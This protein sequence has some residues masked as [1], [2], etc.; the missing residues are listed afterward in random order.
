[1][2]PEKSATSAQVARYKLNARTMMQSRT[3]V[4]RMSVSITSFYQRISDQKEALIAQAP[5][6]ANHVKRDFQWVCNVDDRDV[7]KNS[8]EKEDHFA[9]FPYKHL[10][11]RTIQ[12]IASYSHEKQQRIGRQHRESEE[13]F[14]CVQQVELHREH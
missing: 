2:E 13:P 5:Q 10:Q 11:Q 12:Y 1:M 6:V 8:A 4:W 9:V 7:K 3:V 14:E